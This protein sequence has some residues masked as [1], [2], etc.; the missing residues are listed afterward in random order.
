MALINLQTGHMRGK[1][2]GMVAE[3][4]KGY[5]YV[6]QYAHQP[7][8]RTPAQIIHRNK[9]AQLQGLGSQLLNPYINKYFSGDINTQIPYNRFIKYNWSIWDKQEKAWKMALPFWGYADALTSETTT[10]IK[11]YIGSQIRD[12]T[13]YINGFIASDNGNSIKTFSI[14]PTTGIDYITIPDVN[15][16]DFAAGNISI[17]AFAISSAGLAISNPIRTYIASDPDVN[18]G[19]WDTSPFG[20]L[21]KL[22]W[23]HGIFGIVYQNT[24]VT[25]ERLIIAY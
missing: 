24:T 20:Q 25:N 15:M 4:R 8:P 1:I 21:S 14:A 13:A 5:N 23:T 2:G 12:S 9:Y 11:I 6:R 19:I 10:D 18:N 16:T 3:V 22:S 17:L 7:N